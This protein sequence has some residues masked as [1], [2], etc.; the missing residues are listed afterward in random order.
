MPVR[1]FVAAALFTFVAVTYPSGGWLRDAA[2]LVVFCVAGGL[3]FLLGRLLPYGPLV[4][5]ERRWAGYGFLAVGVAV[6][7]GQVWAVAMFGACASYLFFMAGVAS[8]QHEDLAATQ[9]EN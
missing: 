9:I 2:Q 6:G 7:C 5:P 8:V 1:N 4:H 3:W